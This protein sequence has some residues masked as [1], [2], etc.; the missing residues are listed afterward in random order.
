MEFLQVSDVLLRGL[1]SA[2]AGLHL[3]QGVYGEVL[4]NTKY[5]D[6]AQFPATNSVFNG[7]TT[8]CASLGSYNLAQLAP[9]FSFLSA[10]NHLWATIDFERYRK[11]VD[12]EGYNPVRWME[13]SVSAGLMYYMVAVMSGIVDIK[14]L[15]LLVLTNV[16]LQYT[17]YSIEKDSASAINLD[18]KRS[19][20]SAVRQQ[21]IGF[22]LFFAQMVCI[23]TAFATA[24]TTSEE[25]VP[26]LVWLIVV[27]ITVLFVSF[28]VLSVIYTRGYLRQ[29]KFSERHFRKIEVG[30]IILSFV[31][32]TFLMNSVLFGAVNRE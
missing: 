29:A 25:N 12:D 5:K 9:I 13:Y 16:A 6:K 22:L 31:A 11:Y 10:C 24:V 1:H 20:D 17:G 18:D 30:Y 28:G 32:K 19:Y 2:A 27:F 8:N 23:W 26:W 4:V 3:V 15:I 7:T 14:P 21:V